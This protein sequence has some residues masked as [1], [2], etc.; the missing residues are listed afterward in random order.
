V[1]QSFYF[2]KQSKAKQ[3]QTTLLYTEGKTG[4][5]TSDVAAPG[6]SVQE[7]SK[8]NILKYKDLIFLPSEF[9][10]YRDERDFYIYI[11]FF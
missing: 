10:I 2:Q 5:V 4:G 7:G 1:W 3:Q 9:F 6:S 11:Y 8:M